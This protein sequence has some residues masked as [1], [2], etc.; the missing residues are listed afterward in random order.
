MKRVLTALLSA[1]LLLSLAACADTAGDMI[2]KTGEVV[3]DVGEGAGNLVSRA[4]EGVSQGASKADSMLEGR[5]AAS[6][7]PSASPSPRPASSGSPLME[8]DDGEVRDENGFIGDEDYEEAYD[9][10]EEFAE[11]H[12][13]DGAEDLTD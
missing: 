3:S 1:A 6:P 7:R 9:G 4:G 11:E 2:S 10:V 13:N 8:D 5:N 12:Q